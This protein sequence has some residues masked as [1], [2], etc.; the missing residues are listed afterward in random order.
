MV[1]LP[2]K[3]AV[4]TCCDLQMFMAGFL[5]FTA[6][7][8]ELHYVFTAVWG[9]RVYTLFGILF[10]AFI[11]LLLVTSFVTIVLSYFQLTIEDHRWWWRALISG[12]YV[13]ACWSCTL[14]VS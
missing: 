11:L 8:I 5:P 1:V 14:L 4:S 6:I 12:G 13:P 3:R 10:V 7:Y 9:D 2:A